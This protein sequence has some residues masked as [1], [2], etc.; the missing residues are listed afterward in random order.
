MRVVLDT[1]ILYSA[2]RSSTG[3]SHRVLSALPSG[4]FRPVLSTPLMFEYEEVLFRPRQFPHLRKQDIDDFLDYIASVGDHC[5][6]NFLWR[7][8]LPDPGDDL[9]LEVAVSG[10]AGTIVTYNLSDF[11][12]TEQFGVRVIPPADLIKELKS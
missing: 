5:R 2:L 12:G 3:A 1:G 10:Q 8:C 7:P 4:K 9:V 6:I 11:T